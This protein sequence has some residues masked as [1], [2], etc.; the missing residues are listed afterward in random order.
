MLIHQPVY[1]ICKK[2]NKEKMFFFM[3]FIHLFTVFT[4]YCLNNLPEVGNK[5][6]NFQEPSFAVNF[7]AL[8]LCYELHSK[9]EKILKS[10]FTV[11]YTEQS[12]LKMINLL[13]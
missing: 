4:I 13:M 6:A 2:K 5:N 7:E 10:L 3:S 11:Q 8:I 1:F 9:T 12:G